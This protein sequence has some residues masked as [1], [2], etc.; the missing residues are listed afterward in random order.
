MALS[1]VDRPPLGDVVQTVATMAATNP[2][3]EPEPRDRAGADTCLATGAELAAEGPA[4]RAARPCSEPAP[5]GVDTDLDRHSAP[6]AMT[7]PVHDYDH[8][9]DQDDT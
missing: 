1:N 7:D 6:G 4:A 9:T 8:T 3:A 5:I 2:E